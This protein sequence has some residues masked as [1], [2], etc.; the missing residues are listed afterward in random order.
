MQTGKL[1]VKKVASAKLKRPGRY[2]DGHNL[3]L[4]VLSENNRSWLL[5]YAR[6]GRER[7]LG[8]G[9]LHTVSLSEARKRARAARLK[10]LDGIDPLDQK[11]KEE[12]AAR[13]A[14]IKARTFGQ[15]VEDYLKTHDAAWS[16]K[17]SAQWQMTLTRYCRPIS[18]LS[19]ADI[20]M[21]LV[22]RCL[23]PIWQS[24]TVTAQRLRGRIEKVLSWATGRGLRT[25][26]NP[27][28][29]GG[30]LEVMLAKPGK[31][32]KVEHHAALAYTDL[33]SFLSELRAV[34]DIAARALEFTILTA[35]RTG[36]VIGATADEIDYEAKTWT[37]PAER[38]K[39]GKEHRV[40]LSARALEIL[41]EA[42]REAK[43]NYLFIGHTTGKPLGP[44]AMFNVLVTLRP[45]L[46]VHGFRSTFKDWCDEQT[47]AANHV[48]E[49]ALAHS[50][51]S[52]VEQ[53][54]RRGDLF[55]KR[56]K[57]MEQWSRYCS[58]PADAT[59]KV[60]P[61]SRKAR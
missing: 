2:A 4:Q 19:V 37:V 49:Q 45:G 36:E 28:R 33:G 50:I 20:D 47:N 26:D 15:C 61:L 27:A 8:L 52:A 24:K 31:V 22:L 3:Y 12:A 11:R 55:E 14:A 5:R 34:E 44:M 58:Q 32:A 46:T 6:N 42:P 25:G 51:G 35:A 56:R 41:R 39:A 9:P 38:M 54:Y 40:P 17:H 43:S 23:E 60:V 7:W 30:N 1:T 48:V 57:L 10:L 21:D 29:W 53:A 13:L 18:D 59:G 16:A